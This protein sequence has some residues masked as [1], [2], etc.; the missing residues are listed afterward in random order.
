[1][2]SMKKSTVSAADVKALA[3]DWIQEHLRLTDYKRKCTSGMILSVLLFAASRMRS[4]HDACGRLQGAP[5]DEMLR[6]ALLAS[7]PSQAE[8]ESRLNA[9]LGDRLPKR[10]FKSRRGLRIAID[11]TLI[12]YHGQ[13]SCSQ[14]EIRRGQPKQG[15]TH[16]H[17][18]ATAYVAHHGQRYTLAMTYVFGDENIKD[19][20]RRLLGQVRILGVKVRFLL[21]D[22]EFFNAEVIRYLQAARCPFLMPAFPRGRKPRVPKPGSLHEMASRKKSGR[23]RYSWTGTC[24]LRATV[25]IAIVCRN[26]R[27]KR[28][29]YGR[30]TSLYA[31][32]GLRAGSPRWVYETYRKRF[33]I[34]SSYRQLNTCRIRTSTRQPRLR[35]LFVG[36][37]LILRN[38]WAWCHFNWLSIRSGP[39]I[40]LDLELLPLAELLL[41]LQQQVILEL[42]LTLTRIIPTEGD[43]NT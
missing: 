36:L 23:G 24:G 33:G 14:R 30:R 39:G 32:W 6:Q 18:Y 20:V 10:F 38:V 37:A 16:F 25:N 15:T 1:M 26:Y 34:E 2:R 17:A 35:M 5:S 27:G 7:L 3:G 11:F 22:K 43:V 42:G 13:P 31:Y 21:I 19:V 40:T 41:W 28:G 29:R 4:I 8:L 12:P 9:A